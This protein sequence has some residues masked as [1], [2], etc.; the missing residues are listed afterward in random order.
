MRNN[1]RKGTYLLVTGILFSVLIIGCMNNKIQKENL[2]INPENM[3]TE[4]AP[5]E[6]FFH[7]ANGGWI[8]NNPIGDEYSQY[9]AFTELHE[10][11]RDQLKTLVDEVS[12]LQDVEYGS[13]EQKLRD[14]YNA[15]MDTVKIDAL[16]IKP[17]L[18]FFERIGQIKN[19]DDVQKEI[20]YLH[21]TGIAPLFSFYGSV[22]PGNSTMN[23]A[24]MNQGGLGLSDVDYYTSDDPKS[25]EIR[26]KYV[27]HIA[28]MFVLTGLSEKEAKDYATKIMKL[29]TRLA[30]A[31]LTRLEER[32]PQRT[33]NK[34]S[35]A[36]MQAMTPGFDWGMYIQSIGI[37]NPGDV[38]VRTPKFFEEVSAVVN[39][40]PVDT[41]Q[42]YL[43]WNVL[44]KNANY[45]N[46]EIAKADFDFYRTYLSGVKEMQ[47]RWKRLTSI[48]S[49]Y[50]GEPLGKIYVKK[51]FP[52]EAKQRMEE[53]VGNLKT[54]LAQRIKEAVWMS[55]T[56]KDRA[57]EKLA[58]MTVRVGYPD[59]D[60]WIDYSGFK[61]VEGEFLTNIYNGRKF[62]DHRSLDQ[63]NKPVDRDEW[64]MPPQ[65]VNAGYIPVY[66]QVVF[67]AG[68]LQE[69]FFFM[70]A[71]DAVNYGAI[72][73]VIGHEMTHGFDD[74]GRM[75]DKDGN[76]ADWWM[77]EDV[78]KFNKQSKVLV[79]QFNNYVVLD[80]MHVH[81]ELTLG[82]N[83]ADNGGLNISYVA[84]Q[85]ALNGK[86][87]ADVQGF[88]AEQ[89]FFLAY[90]QLW[91]QV[92][93]DEEMERRLKEDVHSPGISRVN[94]AVVNIPAFYSAFDITADNK[95]FVA[96]EDRAHIW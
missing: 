1:M 64:V 73:V 42:K 52:P 14:F 40:V 80:S 28:R 51:H 55:D 88:T 20:S 72:G 23:I 29:E 15:G 16:G 46:S 21:S 44:N 61:V 36:E 35:F 75:F 24:T 86:V 50:L 4:I 19:A 59:D 9:G 67:P 22:D 68:I 13:P 11:T 74:K 60:K 5:G 82:E 25:K 10:K 57:L 85:K 33:Y 39:D 81:G 76:L 7:Y 26:E 32:D 17:I 47:P 89:R 92:I 94:A 41:W 2:A 54:A 69:P 12:A 70:D 56:T 66:N 83:I 95:L 84:L 37:E 3:K 8:D 65:T 53:L 79:E 87:P 30:K 90:A 63:I 71:D 49:G 93:R 6:D 48:T 38:N 77:P 31:S 91:R 27:G 96:E 45:L 78:V 43:K 34:M 62:F 58:A 18:P